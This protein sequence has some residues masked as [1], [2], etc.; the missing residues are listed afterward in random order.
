MKQLTITLALA[1]ALGAPCVFAADQDSNVSLKGFGTLGVVHSNSSSSD[2]APNFFAPNGAGA[3]RSTAFGVDSK[4]GVQM[5]WKATSAISFTGQALSKYRYDKS[6]SPDLEWAFV[7]FAASSDL[8]VRV[9]RIR[10]A[11][12]L[13]SDYLDVNYANP[14]VRPPLEFYAS[15]PISR[16]EGIDVLWR[17]TVGDYSFLVQPY[18]GTTGKFDL[19]GGNGDTIQFKNVVGANLTATAGDFTYRA[20]YIQVD[21]TY[22]SAGLVGAFGAAGLGGLCASPAKIACAEAAALIPT[23][24]KASFASLGVA[25]DNGE[26]FA[27]GEYGK[28]STESM[29]SDNTTYYVSGGLRTGKWTPYVTYASIKIDSPVK[30]TIVAPS[31]APAQVVGLVGMA[32]GAINQL[33]LSA[34]MS[35]ENSLSVGTRYDL[36]KNIALKAQWDRVSTKKVDGVTGTG[37]GAFR[38]YS[39]AFADRDN[40]V[41]VISFALD[42]VF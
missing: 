17:P 33:L 22:N 23:D 41:K 34:A 16:M 5:D 38:G 31:G 26:Y 6:Y 18:L 37:F 13:L 32:N 24:K 42:F 10:P 1:T 15:A 7:K 12:Y 9:G 35:D 11:V 4:L 29:V 2:Y 25:Y 3:T 21:L 28:R 39:P 14:W 30:S 19:P 20:G 27:S 40:S 36:A 8:D